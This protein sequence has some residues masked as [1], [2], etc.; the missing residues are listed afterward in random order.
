M[1]FGFLAVMLV[2]LTL[3]G[4]VT[5][6]Y[7]STLLKN[8]AEKHIQQTAVQV[9]GRLESVLE[10]INS[11][12]TQVATNGYVQQLMSREAHGH[13]ATFAERQALVPIVTI[14]QLYTDGIRAVELYNKDRARMFPLD[15]GNLGDKVNEAWIREANEKK[16]SIVW[17]GIDPYNPSSLIAI[18]RI[19]LVDQYFSTGGYLLIRAER[20]KFALKGPLT[21]EGEAE[22]MLLIAN[23]GQMITSN[24]ASISQAEADRIMLSDDQTVDIGSRSFILVKQQSAVT[25]WTLLILTPVDTITKGISIL[26]TTIVVSACIG[27]LL[28]MLLSFFLSTIITRPIFRLIKTMR[29]TRL[30][31]LKPTDTVSSTFE[32]K[33]LNYSY[34][35]MVDNINGLIKLVYEKELSRSRTELK[36]LQAQIHPHFL[37]NTLDTLYWSL[38]ER[39]EEQLAAYV[40]AMSDLFRYT[41]TGPNKD[42]WVSLKDELE[43]V[44]RYLLIMKM[45]FEERLAWH[46]DAAAEFADVQLPKLL[47]QPLVENA[48]LHGIESKIEPGRVNVSVTQPAGDRIVI[49]VEDDGAGI[50]EEK[51]RQLREGLARGQVP[52]SKNSGVGIANVQRRLRLYYA[53]EDESHAGIAIESRKGAGTRISIAIPLNR[54]RTI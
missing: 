38:L 2:I 1:L 45:R 26:R 27:T 53:D 28:F 50:D 7:V 41:I 40:V 30:G 37:F 15:N 33:E 5:F 21:E 18:R 19:S 17:F 48:I 52:S 43:H 46:I 10:Q 29:G 8:N 32:I 20:S 24:D 13:P 4:G 23:D 11:L 16:G 14:V 39:D 12:T 36:A 51:L 49:T 42:E 25:G 34:N 31:V 9:N 22:T 3:V 35:Q 6:N 44:Q 54:E 47:L